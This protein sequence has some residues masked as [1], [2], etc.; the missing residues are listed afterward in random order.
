[1]SQLPKPDREQL[2]TKYP[3]VFDRP[4]SSR[5]AMPAMIVGAFAILVFGLVDL[6]FSPSKLFNGMHQLYGRARLCCGTHR[7]WASECNARR[8]C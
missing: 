1:M 6:E 7:A 2:R 8:R 3:D 4:A 5:L